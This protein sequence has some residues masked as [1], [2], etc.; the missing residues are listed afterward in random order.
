MAV[1][2]GP[3]ISVT[4]IVNEF[5]GTAPHSISEYYRGGGLVPNV[6]ANSAIPTSGQ[7]SLSN[8][9]NAQNAVFVTATGG[10]ISYSGDYKIHTFTGPG[11]FTVTQVGNG[12]SNPAGGPSNI[13]YLVVAGG[14][15]AGSSIGGGGGA[16]GQRTSF[17]SPGCNAGS[18]P[19][20]T[21]TYPITVGAG[22]SGGSC[23]NGTNGN[24]S[25]ILT[26]LNCF[27][28]IR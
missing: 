9:Y 15:G 14:G 5:G 12:P 18:F 13:D 10:S 17:P 11:T 4:D 21:T 7:I 6:P 24:P 3:T 16:G 1:P 20:S 19:I 25:F 23:S 26:L 28:V 22:G 8:F 2:A 27:F